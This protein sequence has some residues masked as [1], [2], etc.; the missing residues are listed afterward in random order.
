MVTFAIVFVSIFAAASAHPGQ[1]LPTVPGTQDVD[2]ECFLNES[3]ETL[4]DYINFYMNN[5][6]PSV[7]VRKECLKLINPNCVV[8]LPNICDCRTYF[9]CTDAG[10][11]LKNCSGNLVFHPVKQVCTYRKDYHCPEP[12]EECH[13][14]PTTSSTTSTSST[15]TATPTTTA[16]SPTTAFTTTT[17]PSVW[18]NVTR[19]PTIIPP[20]VVCSY[21]GEIIPDME[22]CH[23]F[24]ECREDFGNKVV[25]GR[26]VI[27]YTYNPWHSA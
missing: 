15:T 23:Y 4:T 20:Y 11:I 5:F 13:I 27:L 19:E 18:I 12:P 1:I 2:Q 6:D 24:F 8:H 25:P 10:P 3:N 22:D 9:T 7:E 16:T 17:T 26:K 14:N 21:D